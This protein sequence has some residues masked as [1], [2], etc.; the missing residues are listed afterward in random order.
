MEKLAQTEAEMHE[1]IRRRWS[2]R[3][4]AD[5]PVEPAKLRSLFEAARWAASCF[6]EQPWSFVVA[7]KE[8]KAAYDAIFASLVPGNQA[9][10]GSAPVLAVSVAKRAFDR[11]GNPNPH[12][13]HDVGLAMGNLCLQATAQGLF[14]HQMMGFVADRIRESFSIPEGHERV[15]AIAI[16]YAGDPAVLP[17]GLRE[18]ELAARERRPMASFVYTETWGSTAPFVKTV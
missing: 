2:P 7:R 12:W 1:L 18:R 17:E 3:S 13:W 15:A 6:N 8:D 5:R 11:N 4:F 16:G 10:A 9:W 14:V